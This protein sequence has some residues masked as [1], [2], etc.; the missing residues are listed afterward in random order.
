[1]AAYEFTKPDFLQNQSVEEILRQMLEQLPDSLDKSEGGFLWDFIHPAALLKAEQSGFVLT[2]AIKSIFPKYSEGRML[3]YHGETRG[4]FRR[5]ASASAVTLTITGI[6]GTIIPKGFKFSTESTPEISGVVFALDEETEIP[7]SGEAEAKAAAE[8]AGP[9]GN[10]AA[11]TITLQV[12][13][14]KGIISVT[15]KEAS[16]GG[17]LEEDDDSLRA[18]IMD[19]DLNQGVSFVGSA[20]DYRR[21][22]LEVSGVG[23]A[24]VIPASEPDGVVTISLTDSNGQPAGQ[25]LCQRVYDHIMRPDSPL[26]RPAPINAFLKVV[27]PVVVDVVVQAV[28]QLE[29]GYTIEDVKKAFLT[30][31]ADYFS[32]EADYM[33][34]AAVVRYFEVGAVLIDT[35]GVLDYTD[36]LLNGSTQNITVAVGEMPVLNP[37]TGIVFTDAE[38]GAAL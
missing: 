33:K 5:P 29:D 6:A 37:D 34:G 30:G 16:Y 35:P 21:W 14:M 17:F 8:I 27:P 26:E 15:N 22:A 7:G 38:S 19:Y 23:N 28:I 13:P 9:V 18:R 2:E 31:M 25:E 11:G 4:I 12:K 32:R 1:M 3:D 20:A 10:T 36:Y 24:L